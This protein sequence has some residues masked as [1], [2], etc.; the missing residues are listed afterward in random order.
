MSSPWRFPVDRHGRPIP[1]PGLAYTPPRSHANGFGRVGFGDL[2]VPDLAVPEFNAILA[3]TP[4]AA[5]QWQSAQQLF[6]TEGTTTDWQRVAQQKFAQAYN[7]LT[8]GGQGLGSGVMAGVGSLEKAASAATGLTI[9]TTTIQGAATA[10]EGLVSAVESGNSVAIVQAFTG[11]VIAGLTISGVAT[12]GVGAA[13]AVGAELAFALGAMLAGKVVASICGKDLTGTP[14]AFMWGCAWSYAQKVTAGPGS[15][16]WRKFPVP[17]APNDQWWYDFPFGFC[18]P[19]LT[20]CPVDYNH[21][22]KSSEGITAWWGCVPPQVL[23][24]DHATYM[25]ARPIDAAFREYKQLEYDLGATGGLDPGYAEFI[26]GYFGAWKA[27][28]EFAFNGLLP[29]GTVEGQWGADCLAAFGQY[30]AFWNAAHSP[31]TTYTIQSSPNG[32]S[33]LLGPFSPPTDHRSFFV[34]Q[35]VYE[36][37][38][39]STP[40]VPPTGSMVINTGPRPA[41]AQPPLHVGNC[42]LYGT[43]TPKAASVSTSSKIVTGVAVAGA[44]GAGAVALYAAVNKMAFQQ[45]AGLIWKKAKG[46]FQHSGA[47]ENPIR[48]IIETKGGGEWRGI[49]FHEKVRTPW[50]PRSMVRTD[51]I[52]RR[53]ST[54]LRRVADARAKYNQEDWES[55]AQN[56]VH[57]ITIDGEWVVV[58]FAETENP[59]RTRNVRSRT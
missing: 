12:M 31:A 48:P 38:R 40:G 18:K 43:C 46:S 50:Y 13:L 21:Q 10:V 56:Y 57:P 19:S 58:H 28:Q 2:P 44:L 6:L 59:I 23:G 45:A 32:F 27:N 9:S 47:R 33:D 5:A 17:G 30:V 16:V 3:N 41:V 35:L 24:P 29:P 49:E 11:A 22:W 20:D 36:A 51:L 37:A 26:R 1:I 8:I 39:I 7:E 25:Y 14:P 52:N 4:A 34:E 55:F 53:M 42:S 15:A 54:I